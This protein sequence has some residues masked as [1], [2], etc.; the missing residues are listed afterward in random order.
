[1]TTDKLTGLRFRRSICRFCIKVL[2]EMDKGTEGRASA[3]KEYKR[4][5]AEIDKKITKI[6]GTPP[7]IV[8][9]LKT[10]KLFG[11]TELGRSK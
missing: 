4:Q 2:D 11:K 6:T 5:L 3:M 7:A 1:M 8:V 10:A 9:G